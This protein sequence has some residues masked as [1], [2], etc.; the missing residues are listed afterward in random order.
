MR[1]NH[2]YGDEGTIVTLREKAVAILFV[3]GIAA[4]LIGPAATHYDEHRETVAQT[5]AAVA[6]H[7]EA[8]TVPASI[9]DDSAPLHARPAT[10]TQE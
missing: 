8:R 5:G 3:I 6:V 4:L 1:R 2:R 9:P 7:V 10:K